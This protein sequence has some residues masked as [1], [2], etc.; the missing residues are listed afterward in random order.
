M[1]DI[2]NKVRETKAKEAKVKAQKVATTNV[3]TYIFYGGALKAQHCVIGVSL[4]HP[5]TT[6]FN[7]LTLYY[8]PELKGAY[9]K[10]GLVAEDIKDGIKFKLKNNQLTDILFNGGFTNNKKVLIEI[11]D[12]KRWTTIN[13]Y[14]KSGDDGAS[15]KSNSKMS[16]GKGA[17]EPVNEL[18][19]EP[20]PENDDEEEEEEPEEEGSESEEEEEIKQVIP[21]PKK[22]KSKK[23]E[24]VAP[25]V[26]IVVEPVKK[27]KSKKVAQVEPEVVEPAKKLSKKKKAPETVEPP[28]EA[29]AEKAPR[30]PKADK[31]EPVLNKKN[32]NKNSA[33][34]ELSDEQDSKTKNL[35]VNRTHP[36]VIESESED[37]DDDEESE[38]SDEN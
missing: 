26:P 35:K 33:Q 7:N 1:S 14:K 12:V 9:C 11:T 38:E 4:E 23:A 29:K 27:S 22:S 17:R 10:S 24:P 28:K 3:Y 6:I 8:G 15:V 21:E 20:E 25:I 32:L 13:V 36:I 5:E 18:A 34:I 2:A 16:T 19:Q 30:A 37:D 31:Q